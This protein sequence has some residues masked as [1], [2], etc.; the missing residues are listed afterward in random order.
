MLVIASL[1]PKTL[2]FHSGPKDS[3]AFAIPALSSIL[4]PDV[5]EESYVCHLRAIR[6]YLERTQHLRRNREL[7]FVSHLAFF[8]EI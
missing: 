8:P 5:L 3:L 6:V 1:L 7:F 2:R 4:G